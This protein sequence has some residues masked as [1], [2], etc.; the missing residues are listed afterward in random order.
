MLRR[1][2][3][4]LILSTVL[5]L[6][7]ALAVASN[8][9]L[10]FRINQRSRTPTVSQV[11]ERFIQAVGGRAAWLK[12]KSQ[13]SAGTIEVLA[14]GNKGTYEGYI[15]APTQILILMRFANGEFRSGFD[16]QRGW[17]QTL[18][19][20]AQYDPPAKQAASKRDADFYKYLN[21]KQHFPNAKVTGIE[22]VEGAKTYVIE[23]TPAGEKLPERLYFSV[24]TGLLVR[25]DTS[26]E[27][28]EGK[29]ATDIQYYDDYREV[30]GIK[31]AFG[32]RIV[33]GNITIVTKHSVFKNNITM[34][35]AIF[36]LPSSK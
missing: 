5:S 17:S 10:D 2:S 14:V 36:K 26:S 35:D 13:Y 24:S 16:G 20:G 22:D 7:Q 31:V 3:L 28:S 25:R 4:A 9:D 34:D 11:I 6:S 15:K 8:H 29:K 18:Q 12:I 32:L 1:P 21:F 30:D 27:D 23:A 19:N 33:Q